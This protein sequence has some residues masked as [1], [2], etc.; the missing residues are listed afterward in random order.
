MSRFQTPNLK[1][2]VPYVPGEQPREQLLL[3]LNTNE[4][5]FP[6]SEGVKQAVAAESER[7]QLYS[8]PTCL[9]LREALGAFLGVDPD[10][11]LMTNGSDQILA[12]AFS[13]F[14][15]AETPF[16]CPSLTYGFY[17][18][19]AG[20][21]HIPYETIPLRDDFTIDPAQYEGLHKNIAFANPNAPTGCA[22]SAAEVE[23]IVAANPDR[24]VIVDEAYV[25]FGGETVVPLIH[26]YDNLLVTRT[27]SK[28]YSLAG[29]RLG[30]GVGNRDLINDLNTL[31]YA[32]D[33]YAVNRM[34]AAAGIAALQDHAYYRANCD[35]IMQT[36]AE[37]KAALE[38]LGFCVADSR[39]NFLFAS[40][41][42]MDGEALYKALRGRGILVRH[43]DDP[44]IHNYNRITVGTREQMQQL[45]A[46]A[47]TILKEGKV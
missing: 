26:K 36:R 2:L 42:D 43:F 23:R 20:L 9:R 4:S 38:A 19:L 22:L 46:A 35:A 21:Y 47:E 34:T 10:E 32:T 37:A 11:I 5:P 8:D 7:L 29:A 13:S 28:S 6:P 14:G 41:P 1:D 33:P 39:A 44:A 27:F 18:V 3:K 30:Y 16:V 25:D 15:D 17:P 24:V 40:H 45:L 12:L 31:K